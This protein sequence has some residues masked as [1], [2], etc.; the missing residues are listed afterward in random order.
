MSRAIKIV[1][2][3]ANNQGVQPERSLSA[4]NGNDSQRH[5]DSNSYTKQI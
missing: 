2:V 4:Q 3:Q 5:F 1:D